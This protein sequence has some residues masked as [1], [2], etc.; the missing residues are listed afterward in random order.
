MD[1]QYHGAN[2]ITVSH[3]GS[4]ILVDDNLSELGLKS[5]TK[6]EDVSLTTDG[7]G[8]KTGRL[9]FNSPGEYEVSEVSI[10]GIPARGQMDE[11]G[12]HST[13]MFKLIAGDQSILVTGRIYPELSDEQIE[14]IGRVDVMLVPVGGNGYSTDSVGALKLIKSV[15]PKLVIPTHFEDKSIKYPVPQKSLSE[16]LTELGMEPKETLAKLKLKPTDLSDVTQLVILE[17]V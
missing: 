4:K 10:I 12:K 1:I 2:C 13:T 6:A 9:N 5:I 8:S 14:A 17:K 15:E 3:K 11:E 7:K 16:A